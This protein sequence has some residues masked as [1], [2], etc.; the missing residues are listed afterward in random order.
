MT[1]A[2]LQDLITRNVC[3]HDPRSAYYADL[4][5]P[6]DADWN[7]APPDGCGSCDCCFYGRHALAAALD[8]ATR[9]QPIDTAPKDGTAVLVFLPYSGSPT[10]ATARWVERYIFGGQGCWVLCEAGDHAESADLTYPAPTHWKPLGP[11]PE[12]A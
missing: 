8:R 1:D 3:T 4:R 12:E 10:Q 2:G 9:W 6:A 7:D 5:D 11:N